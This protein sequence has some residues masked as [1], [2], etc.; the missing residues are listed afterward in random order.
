MLPLRRLFESLLHNTAII[1]P[2]LPLY[3]CISFACSWSRWTTTRC[4]HEQPIYSLAMISTCCDLLL[5]LFLLFSWHRASDTLTKEAFLLSFAEY[6][7]AK[8]AP[9]CATLSQERAMSDNS[10]STGSSGSSTNS[11]TLLS[12]EVKTH[13]QISKLCVL[14]LYRASHTVIYIMCLFFP[15][16]TVSFKIQL[17]C[18]C[19]PQLPRTSKCFA[20]CTKWL[21]SA[22]IYSLLDTGLATFPELL[23]PFIVL[24]FYV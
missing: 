23:C 22:D 8:S 2:T 3:G 19:S 18:T 7:R 17:V 11:W 5:L 14:L 6:S 15:V 4:Q 9:C 21:T 1:W 13:N 10:H 24:H 20:K 12:P 16:D